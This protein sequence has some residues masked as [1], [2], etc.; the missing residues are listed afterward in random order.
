MYGDVNSYGAKVMDG[1]IM[2]DF[3]SFLKIHF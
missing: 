1:L 2:G 3:S